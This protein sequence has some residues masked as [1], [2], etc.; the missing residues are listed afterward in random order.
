[1]TN[2]VAIARNTSTAF[3]YLVDPHTAEALTFSTSSWGGREA[4]TAL[5]DA[6]A[7][8]RLAHPNALP[9]VALEAAPMVTKYGRKSKPTFR[10]AGWKA[11][12]I[13]V[14]EL[15]PPSDEEFYEP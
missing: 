4:V 13:A 12:D 8:M 6:I 7:R 5:G 3:V 2:D 10:I 15:L 1:M 9:I 14:P 11:A